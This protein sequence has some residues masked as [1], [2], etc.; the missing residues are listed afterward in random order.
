MTRAIIDAALALASY[1]R[2]VFPCGTHKRPVCRNGFHAATT[3]PTVIRNMFAPAAAKL[4][5]VPCGED[6][7]FDVLDIDPK[8]RGDEW[9]AANRDRLPLTR[10]HRTRSGGL[11]MLFQHA[12]GVRNSASRVAPGIDVRGTGG[13]IVAPPSPG[14]SV[15]IA[16]PIATWP[17]WLLQ[18]GMVLPP[19]PVPSTK[20]VSSGDEPAP[21]TDARYAAYVD[22]LL[23]TLGRAK[24]G[25]KH[26]VLLRVGRALGGVAE[27]A[28]I[29]DSDAVERL[30]AA[31]PDTVEDYA[32]AK[33]TAAWAV[34]KGRKTAI[35]LAD[36]E[37]GAPR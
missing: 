16:A 14:Y 29:T 33:D 11:H 34:A 4:I 17:E 7:G 9:L 36:R 2:P 1:G 37:M 10:S 28:G 24:D 27:A 31:M 19:A 23:R 22:K 5:G 15:E 3:E 13:Y 26:Y 20:T 21:I 32:A 8:N 18:P 30:V 6:T 25:E 35:Q 12:D